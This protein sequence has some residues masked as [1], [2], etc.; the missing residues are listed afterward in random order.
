M[1]RYHS[2]PTLALC[3][4]LS[5]CFG[6]PDPEPADE[7]TPPLLSA[8]EQGDLVG[9]TRLL[10]DASDVDVRDACRWTPLMKAALNGH[11]ETA[12]RLIEAGAQVDL[13]DKGGYSALMLAA[14]RNHTDLVDLLLA[15]GADPNRVE[16]T[17]G[18]T[19]LIWAAQLGHRATVER[20]IDA[21]ADPNL[22]DFSGKRASDRARENGHEEIAMM[23]DT[24]AITP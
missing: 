12:R 19:A 17:G 3:L 2:L 14:S 7:I 23:L 10:S 13:T 5:A 24:P 21:S 9:L 11:L 16:Q 1:P 6:E 18:F 4:I 22:K 8:A 15:S 20:L